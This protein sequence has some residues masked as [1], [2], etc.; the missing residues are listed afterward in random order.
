MTKD[1]NVSDSGTA[2]PGGAAV[3]RGGPD[4]GRARRLVAVVVTCNRWPHL[5]RCLAA[6]LASP[7]ALLAAVVVV[8]NASSDGTAEWLAA[9][10]GA[11]CA[12]PS[13]TDPRLDVLRL[14]VNTGGAGGFAAG[15]AHALARHAP[16]WLVLLDDDAR[17]APG[18]LAAFHTADLRGWDAVAAAVTHPDGRV[19]DMNRPTL[20]PFAH[21]RVFWATLLGGGRG[22][23]HLG[24]D[25]YARTQPLAV[26][27]A[28]FVGFF[29][30]RAAVDRLGL[31]EAR[32]F[33]YGDDAIYTLRL[34]QSGGRIG[35]FPGLR[36]VHDS[37]TLGAGDGR[38]R[39]LWKVYYYHRN[40]LI[41]YR[42]AA[43]WL[44]WPV[45]GVVLPV[46]LLRVRA[47][48]GARRMFLRLLARAVRDGI[49][50][51]TELR[52]AQV[53]A[54]AGGAGRNP[55]MASQP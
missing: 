5:Q 33:L 2:L 23:F 50:G 45:L 51:R 53:L 9:R 25:A 30:S 19:C 18:A 3:A 27:G 10:A 15:M 17:P 36:F 54:L 28:S 11:P 22:A 13:P 39:P 6:L 20:N 42:L 38:F 41:L 46:W 4:A 40:L 49:A 35:F 26:D 47:H 32:L 12:E 48:E 37:Q 31:P 7:P 44:F 29:V 21:R 43:G 34:S 55:A 16:D 8:D 24:A 1:S 14:A 52:H